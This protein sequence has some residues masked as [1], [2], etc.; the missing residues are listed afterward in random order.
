MKKYK[1]LI[2]D[3]DDTLAPDE[4]V[5]FESLIETCKLAERKYE[6]SAQKLFE[7]IL[8]R[9]RELWHESPER[10]YCVRVGVSSWE[11]LWGNF[12]GDEE[13]VINLNNWIEEYRIQSWTNTLSDFEINDE[14]LAH[15]MAITYPIERRSRFRLEQDAKE[16]LGYARHHYRLGLLTNG[17]SS[18]QREKVEGVGIADSFEVILVSGE[19]GLGKPA[20]KVFEIMLDKLRVRADESLM[21]GNSLKSDIAGAR[22]V[23]MDCVFV[24]HKNEDTSD[25]RPTYV[26]RELK[27]L[28]ALL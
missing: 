1:A 21:I 28:Y 17:T 9:C 3:L 20:P 25:V 26:I 24:D 27:E 23:G 6:V 19:A 2:F 7:S 12:V 10:E 5:C 14:E 15:L 18:I 11:G 13:S 22:G 8:L 16:I 4:P